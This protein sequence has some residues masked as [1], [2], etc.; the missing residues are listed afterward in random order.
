MGAV[1]HKK[2]DLFILETFYSF[3]LHKKLVF[4]DLTKMNEVKENEIINLVMN[5][6]VRYGDKP[7]DANLL[8]P[9]VF[10]LFRHVHTI[11]ITAGPYHTFDLLSFLRMLQ[12]V[13]LPETLR[14]ITID[15]GNAQ[16]VQNA[17][18]IVKEEYTAANIEGEM[19][20]NEFKR[21]R[22]RYLYLK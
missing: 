4:L 6:L 21:G 22:K 5:P 20:D 1:K 7:K 10:N 3:T 14:L 16:W 17:F 13:D 8:K 9:F 11:R 19:V 18:D 15:D 12:S 2:L